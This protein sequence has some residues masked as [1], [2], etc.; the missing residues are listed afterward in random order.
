V[1][2]QPFG[3]NEDLYSNFAGSLFG[4]V[5]RLGGGTADW[6]ERAI[7][8]LERFHGPLHSVSDTK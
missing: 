3:G 2:G 5:A 1:G 6:A 8:L 7:G 4:Q